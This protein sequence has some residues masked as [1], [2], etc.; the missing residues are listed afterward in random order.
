MQKAATSGMEQWQMPHLA[1]PT[2]GN[3]VV[4]VPLPRQAEP[5]LQAPVQAPAARPAQRIAPRPERRL[6]RVRSFAPR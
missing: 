6:S 1:R 3:A 4:S 5:M 2:S